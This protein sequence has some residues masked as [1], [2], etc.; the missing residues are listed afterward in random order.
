MK[1][2]FLSLF[3]VFLLCLPTGC[4]ITSIDKNRDASGYV[5]FIAEFHKRLFV[6]THIENSEQ[7]YYPD[8]PN[9]ESSFVYG[10][11][12]VK[13]TAQYENN[14]IIYTV[15]KNEDKPVVV[16]AFDDIFNEYYESWNNYIEKTDVGDFN[17]VGDSR[18]EI[19]ISGYQYSVF[20]D[21]PY[22]E[23]PTI[24]YEVVTVN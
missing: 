18:I 23:D 21:E 15:D 20:F 14:R 11:H 13:F 8:N 9:L 16:K 22:L 4:S 7:M 19:T 17:V 6:E 3:L 10:S 1:N 2:A 12:N 24:I 5:Q